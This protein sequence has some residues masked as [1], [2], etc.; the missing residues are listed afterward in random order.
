[1][2]QNSELYN[3]YQS[4]FSKLKIGIW[5]YNLDAQEFNWDDNC[6]LLYGLPEGHYKSQSQ[7]WFAKVHE[8]DRSGLISFFEKLSNDEKVSDIMFRIAVN[9]DGYRILNLKAFKTQSNKG[10]V[11]VGL[12]CEAHSKTELTPNKMTIDLAHEINNPLLIIQGKAILLKKRVIQ[13]DID[14]ECCK[15]DLDSIRVNCERIDK[16]IKSLNRE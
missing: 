7:S 16:V 4:V 14:I 13:N 9:S 5:E 1:M 15:K 3:N 6:R 11:L 12:Q 2:N 8:E 10:S